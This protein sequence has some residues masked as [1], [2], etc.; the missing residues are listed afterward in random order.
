MPSQSLTVNEFK[1]VLKTEVNEVAKSHGWDYNNQTHRGQSFQ[2]W[3]ANLFCNYD[4]GF[5]T[6]AEDSL[7]FSQDL[8]ADIV[9]E[10]SNRRYLLIAQCKFLSLA[11]TPIAVDETEVNDFFHRH[12]LFL[13]RDW[14]K[15]HGSEQAFDFLGDYKEKVQEGYTVEY[16]F[17][18]TGKASDRIKELENNCNENYGSRGLRVKCFLFDFYALKDYFVRSLSLEENVPAE[19]IIQLSEVG[20]LQKTKPFE[21]L[22]TIVKG[23]TLRDL[24]RRH[25]EALFAWNIRGYLG[26]RG[27]NST[28]IDTADKQPE[29]F[30]YFN[31]GVSAICTGYEIQNHTLHATNFQIINGAQT[32]GA[33][34]KAEPK[35]NIDVLFRLTK[36]A[37]V[38]TEKG[39]NIDIIRYNNSQNIIKTSDFHSNDPIQIW[40]E[41][42]FK[43]DT[44]KGPNVPKI[45]YQRRRGGTKKTMGHSIKLEELAKIRYAF[46]HEPT[47]ILASPKDLWTPE[48]D[49]G[50]YESS[51]GVEG[52]LPDLWSPKEFHRCLLAI[53]FH[54]RIEAKIAE[55][56][57]VD[58]EF[59]F[60]RRLRFHALSLAGHYVDQGQRD[61]DVI[62]LLE[63]GNYFDEVWKSFWKEAFRIL[64]EV[65]SF[66][67]VD[68]KK[69]LY[70]LARSGEDWGKMLNRFSRYSK[71][72]T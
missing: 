54:R 26:N 62:K 31:N 40:L 51:F 63:D 18:S 15:K 35:P 52:T 45:N 20:Y 32:V 1:D 11:K 64:D 66:M 6:E 33:L 60:L 17:V 9:L 69:S 61:D 36:S 10:D 39:I 72:T 3:T 2:L 13:D 28:I 7:L 71:R 55:E 58:P 16:Y 4:K 48:A 70:A 42:K 8:K 12:E 24:Y 14:V 25:K 43:T 38:K 5:D 47:L 44:P 19:V 68:Q 41:N 46:L 29:N 49:K 27:V 56:A 53:A 30:F 67:V 50:A 22:V 59:K 21:T 57:K 23:N 34:A 65:Y 37:S